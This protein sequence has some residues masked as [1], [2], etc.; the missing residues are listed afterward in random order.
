MADFGIQAF[1]PNGSIS[2]DNSNKAGIY[3]ETLVLGA[4]TQGNKVYSDVP[5][6]YLYF[7]VLKG[8]SAHTITTDADSTGQ[9]RL[10]WVYN[11]GGNGT[12]ATTVIIFAKKTNRPDPFGAVLMNTSGEY[13]ADLRYPVPQHY[14]RITPTDSGG[15]PILVAVG[16][17]LYE[18][19]YSGFGAVGGDN[20]IMLLS[21]PD[22]T[23]DD[24]WYAFDPYIPANGTAKVYV[25]SPRGYGVTIKL[26]SIHAYALSGPVSAGKPVGMQY[27]L[28]GGALTYDILADNLTIKDTGVIT[29]GRGGL[30]PTQVNEAMVTLNLAFPT[31]CGV[32]A[33]FF[34]SRYTGS[35]DTD[36]KEYY[37][38]MYQRK[39]NVFNYQ[40][41]FIQG[42]RGGWS[43]AVMGE[44]AGSMHGG[45]LIVADISQVSPAPS[46]YTF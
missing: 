10:T 9:A 37:L 21:L 20:R 36:V 30:T 19:A 31:T 33:P 23:S 22:S 11:P 45:G 13:L 32:A 8:D 17:I 34:R 16:G 35:S 43:S 40:N 44:G 41:K 27:F 38:G 26:P 7:T 18:R 46:I 3:V 39:G 42:T 1:R 28:P 2:I 14:G 29:M 12:A 4:G 6:G 24:L 5:G 15:D 25:Y